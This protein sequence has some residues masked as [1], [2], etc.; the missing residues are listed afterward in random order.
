MVLY[1]EVISFLQAALYILQ[2]FF[3][4]VHELI[5]I[6]DFIA[7]ITNQVM[8]VTGRTGTGYQLISC[9]TFS[10]LKF[11]CQTIRDQQINGSVHGSHSNGR[12]L[13]VCFKIDFFNRQM[14]VHVTGENGQDKI[15]TIGEPDILLQ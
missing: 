8:V 6:D 1:P 14:L 13:F 9:F 11:L 2:E 3:F 10:E 4:F 15:P 5:V 12:I 7:V